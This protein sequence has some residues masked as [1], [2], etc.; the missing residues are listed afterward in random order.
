MIRT[1][2]RPGSL[3][4][5]VFPFTD[6]FAAK[7]RPALVLLAAGGKFPLTVR[8]DLDYTDRADVAAEVRAAEDRFPEAGRGTSP[9]D[10]QLSNR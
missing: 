1:A 6:L 4:T 10:G 5:A 8:E 9:G 2:L 7:R 3:V